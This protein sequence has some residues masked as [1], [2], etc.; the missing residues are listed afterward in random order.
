MYTANKIEGAKDMNNFL[1]RIKN[2]FANFYND[3]EGAQIVEYAL[4]I[5][6]VSIILVIALKALGG[7]SFS[8]FIARVNTCLTTNSCT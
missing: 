2:T 8:S 6:V 4:I 1:A 5:A 7:G 3:E